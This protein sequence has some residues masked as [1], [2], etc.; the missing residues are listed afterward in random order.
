MLLS[1]FDIVP[2]EIDIMVSSGRNPKEHP[3]MKRDYIFCGFGRYLTVWYTPKAT[4][5]AAIMNAV[6]HAHKHF[7]AGR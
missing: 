1:G 4:H 7:F 2:P 5:G 3:G 6:N